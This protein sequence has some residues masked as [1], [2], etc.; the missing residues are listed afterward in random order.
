MSYE[1]H[2]PIHIFLIL[3]KTKA[4]SW[5]NK[6]MNSNTTTTWVDNSWYFLLNQIIRYEFYYQNTWVTEFSA[7]DNLLNHNFIKND[8]RIV[9]MGLYYSYYS[10]FRSIV[11]SNSHNNSSSS[12]DLIF[13]NCN[14][15]E[16]EASEMYGLNFLFKSDSRKLLLDYSKIEHPMLKDF[17]SEGIKDVFYDILD[18]QVTYTNNETTEL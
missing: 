14:W 12:V 6:S 8:S 15:L 2:Y 13:K 1:N 3:E 16:R 9:T 5:S 7:I 4:V 10:K 18:N 17:P 11:L